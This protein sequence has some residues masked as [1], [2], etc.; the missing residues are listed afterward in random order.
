M[1]FYLKKKKK[2]RDLTCLSSGD[3]KRN[4]LCLIVDARRGSWRVARSYIRRS[5]VL[6]GNSATRVIVIRPDGFWEKRV[7]NCTKSRKDGEVS[8][9]SANLKIKNKIILLVV[10]FLCNGFTYFIQPIYIPI[11]RLGAYVEAGQ[12]PFDLGGSKSYDHAG[13]IQTRVVI[14]TFFWQ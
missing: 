1:F 2:D 3:T 9:D 13:W 4:G 11:T 5:I 6:V 12:L 10:Y 7:D 14:I 8:Q